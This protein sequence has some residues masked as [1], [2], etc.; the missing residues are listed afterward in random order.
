MGLARERMNLDAVGL[1]PEV[2][3]TIQCARAQSTRS[4]YDNKWR[5]FERWC[6]QKQI[7]PY[8]CSVSEVLCFLQLMLDKGEAF[9][10]I[11]VYLAA[12]SACHRFWR[13]ESTT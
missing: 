3:H 11:K 7:T 6:D 9:S 5:V 13:S 1:P 2:I 10:T 8:L 4:L 12:I